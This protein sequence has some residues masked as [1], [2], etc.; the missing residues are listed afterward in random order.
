MEFMVVVLKASLLYF[1]LWFLENSEQCPPQD[2]DWFYMHKF[3]NLSFTSILWN[4]SLMQSI[5][6]GIYII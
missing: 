4:Y 5:K 6:D 2:D 3:E 1:I